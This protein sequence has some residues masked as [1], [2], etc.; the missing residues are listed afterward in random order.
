MKKRELSPI[1]LKKVVELR[2]LGAKWT[3]IQQETKVERRAA[4]RA[5]EE[6][7]RDKK[8]RQQEAARFRVAA[9][10][11]H[12]HVN[13]L[14]KLATFLVMNLPVPPLLELMDKNG[15]QF[16]SRL[17]EQD[18]LERYDEPPEPAVDW[19]IYRREKVLLFESL[20]AHTCDEVRLKALDE[21]KEARDKAVRF[22]G[23][24]REE[25]SETVN[26]FVHEERQ[27]NLLSSI[28]KEG[29]EDDPVKRMAEAVLREIWQ[30]ILR[31]RLDE[32]E[33]VFQTVLGH[34]P[35]PQDIDII[36]VESRRERHARV[37]VFIGITNRSLA[38]K[39]TDV[40]NLVYGNLCTRDTVQ[41]LHCEVGEMT[42]ASDELREMLNPVKLRPMI[43]RTRCDLCPA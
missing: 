22:L 10:A 14:I 5:Y 31:D 37:L 3:E 27:T 17:W 13:D 38:E 20:K 39:V 26:K 12:E 19:Q 2:E 9:E 43:L 34:M 7:Q 18:I 24:L 30:A 25:A 28:C 4:K 6:W 41:Q 42:K 23:K 32:E 36:N 40:C 8:M 21:W 15:E 29:G 33:P 16:L 35:P 11:F 1:E